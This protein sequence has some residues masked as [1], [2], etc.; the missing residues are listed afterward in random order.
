ME[1][2]SRGHAAALP[3]RR[4]A[5]G[6]SSRCGTNSTHEG[7][8]SHAS[9]APAKPG[10]QAATHLPK[11]LSSRQPPQAPRRRSTTAAAT[12]RAPSKKWV[13]VAPRPAH[14]PAPPPPS[15]TKTAERRGAH[16]RGVRAVGEC[17]TVDDHSCRRQP[18]HQL[19]LDHADAHTATAAAMRPPTR[20]ATRQQ[21][22]RP[23][24][25]TRM[26][27]SLHRWVGRAGHERACGG[28][29]GE[30]ACSK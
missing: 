23:A 15:N 17:P 12:H 26:P 9:L 21:E 3:S 25:A 29:R 6:G 22:W 20:A 27:P 7:Q 16:P 1:T 19:P 10:M 24:A 5:P 8:V 2:P 18:P 28:G 4:S 11:P 13:L 14:T 30:G